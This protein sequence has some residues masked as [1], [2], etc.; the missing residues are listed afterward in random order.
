MDQEEL[1]PIPEST[2]GDF[3]LITLFIDK[4]ETKKARLLLNEV[5]TVEPDHPRLL[6]AL[7]A[8][9]YIERDINN[10]EQLYLRIIEIAP[11]FSPPYCNLCMLYSS[12]RRDEDAAKYANL[13]V[14]S[15]PR[16]AATWNTL[17]LYYMNKGDHESALEYFVA[18]NRIDPG[19][20]IAVYNLACA[21]VQLGDIDKGLSYLKE[22]LTFV[23]NYLKSFD[24]VDLDPIR[25]L[26]KFKE[27]MANAEKYHSNAF[28]DNEKI[29]R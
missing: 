7:A 10:T 4:R 9:Y 12:L 29:I 15:N 19:F 13:A 2:S 25:Q 6:N 14:D 3:Q 18:A 20:L 11:D 28:S 17:G 5:L 8:T 16:S 22:S 27:I 21:Y 24:D 26:P 1:Y 23:N